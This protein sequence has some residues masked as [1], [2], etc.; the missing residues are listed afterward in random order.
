MSFMCWLLHEFE[1]DEDRFERSPGS[2]YQACALGESCM[3]DGFFT[4]NLVTL[5]C[6]RNQ[7]GQQ[8]TCS[9]SPRLA[10]R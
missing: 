5:R 9:A 2:R 1:G 3:Q 6:F 10:E 4:K 7:L 8:N